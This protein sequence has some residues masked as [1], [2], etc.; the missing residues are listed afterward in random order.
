MA[1]SD[2]KL[3]GLNE[4]QLGTSHSPSSKPYRVKI[5][6][7]GSCPILFHKWN[8]EDVEAKAKATKGSETKKTDNIEAYLWRDLDGDICIPGEYLRQ[9]IIEA[10][11]YRQD[12]R[13][14][15]KSARD[16][17]K[18][19][20]ISLTE[21][22]SLG[23]SEPDYIDKRRVVIMRSAV[24]RSRPAVLEGYKAEFIFMVQLPEYITPKL[25]YDVTSD[26]GRLCGVGDFRP[27]YGRFQVTHF[28]VLDDNFD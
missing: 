13:N 15:R 6:I 9:S 11:K 16:L 1:S 5:E 14:S 27:S 23:I 26:A 3:V 22:A 24:T 4:E 17:F 18:A 25:L 19:G 2:S 12:P 21:L 8:C 7:T 10:S 28:E 20:L